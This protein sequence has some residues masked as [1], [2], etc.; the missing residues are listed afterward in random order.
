MSLEAHFAPVRSGWNG[1]G[2]AIPIQGVDAEDGALAYAP[3]AR[4]GG[5]WMGMRG[6]GQDR[7]D[8]TATS[9]AGAEDVALSDF[10]VPR[11]ANAGIL[12]GPWPTLRGLSPEGSPSLDRRLGQ[13]VDGST[14]PAFVCPRGLE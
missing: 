9:P 2:R 7:H 14:D 13:L 1:W 6:D 4:A 10:V 11:F 5:W 3:R 12:V 8:P